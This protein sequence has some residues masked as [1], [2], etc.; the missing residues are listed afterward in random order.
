MDRNTDS[1]KDPGFLSNKFHKK[2]KL[3]LSWLLMLSDRKMELSH[4]CHTTL[5]QPKTL[6]EGNGPLLTSLPTLGPR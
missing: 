5:P 1:C 6:L 2:V 3:R 4:L